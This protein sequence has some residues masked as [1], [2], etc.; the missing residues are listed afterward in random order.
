MPVIL[1]KDHF[2]VLN[3]GLAV[4]L[5]DLDNTFSVI[6]DHVISAGDK[7]NGKL[8]PDSVRICLQAAVLHRFKQ[9]QITVQCKYIG[10]G[11]LLII[12]SGYFHI[13]GQPAVLRMLP[14][15]IKALAGPERDFC[16][17]TAAMVPAVFF[18]EEIRQCNA[19]LRHAGIRKSRSHD[20]GTAQPLPARGEIAAEQK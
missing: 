5:P 3:A 14:R 11:R 1:I 15:H 8:F 9:G 20:N 7:E 16:E 19:G 2:Q 18:R 12:P 4:H 17:Q 6:A 13:L 10:A